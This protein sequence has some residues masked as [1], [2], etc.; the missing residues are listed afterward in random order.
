[1]GDHA[2]GSLKYRFGSFEGRH[3]QAEAF[4]PHSFNFMWRG[5]IIY[6]GVGVTDARINMVGR[7]NKIVRRRTILFAIFFYEIVRLMR[8]I[9]DYQNVN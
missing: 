3:I 5:Y 9:L 6:W 4:A 1:M 7:K 2:S 8:R